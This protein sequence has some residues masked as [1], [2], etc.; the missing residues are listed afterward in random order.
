MCVF[1]TYQFT[2]LELEQV[3]KPQHLRNFVINR[4]HVQIITKQG[5]FVKAKKDLV[6]NLKKFNLSVTWF[7]NCAMWSNYYHIQGKS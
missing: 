1:V 3:K 2:D 7:E 5:N 4:H 6:Q